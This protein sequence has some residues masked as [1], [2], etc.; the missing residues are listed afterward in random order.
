[1][2]VRC[3]MLAGRGVLQVWAAKGDSEAET[4]MRNLIIGLCLFA[5]T[6]LEA[7]NYKGNFYVTG[8]TNQTSLATDSTGK[9]TGGGAGGV[10]S[11]Q[12]VAATNSTTLTTQA[13][14]TSPALNGLSITNLDYIM[15][16]NNGGGS[17]LVAGS[18]GTHSVFFI[19]NITTATTLAAFTFWANGASAISF[20]ATCSGGTDRVLTFPTGC[21]SV[22][23][24][25]PAAVTITNGAGANFTVLS[26]PGLQTNVSWEPTRH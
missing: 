19:T 21:D 15:G 5:A 23:W 8:Q 3:G 18:P 24:G 13:A 4:F 16:T 25:A 9:I 22:Q 14:G 12:L 17:A 10:T 2:R 26:I 20:H 7:S 6:L 1:V 11:G